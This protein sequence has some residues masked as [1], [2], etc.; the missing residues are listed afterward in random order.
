MFLGSIHV[1]LECYGKKVG[2]SLDGNIAF[3]L[4]EGRLFFYT[5]AVFVDLRY[6]L[7]PLGFPNLKDPRKGEDATTQNRANHRF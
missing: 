6:I 1:L 5:N 2:H 7:L 4:S 3:F